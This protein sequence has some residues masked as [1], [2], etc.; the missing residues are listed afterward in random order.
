MMTLPV[1]GRRPRAERGERHWE[2][3]TTDLTPQK[4]VIWARL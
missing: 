1:M 4:A 3:T 2:D